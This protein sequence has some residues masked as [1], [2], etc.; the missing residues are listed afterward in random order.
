MIGLGCGARSYT[1]RLHYSTPYAVPR[2]AVRAVLEEFLA[3]PPGSFDAADHGIWLDEEDQR[4][5]FVILSLLQAAG[6]SLAAYRSR[7]AG[8]VLTDLPQLRE[9]QHRDLA[10][11]HDDCLRLTAAGM[12]RSDAI[13]PWLV[14]DKV[15]RLMEGYQWRIT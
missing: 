15:R 6:L 7:F 14:S 5:R 13:G 11:F 9:L 1:R 2:P 8:E 10:E 12:E 3:R 4:R